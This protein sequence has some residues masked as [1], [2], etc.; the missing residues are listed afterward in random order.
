MTH[1]LLSEFQEIWCV[2]F[3]FSAPP[4]N[5]ARPICLV[6]KEVLTGRT[7]KYWEDDLRRLQS[8][9]YGIDTKALVVAYYAS[10][11][12]GCHLALNWPIPVRL[13]DLCA[14]FRNLTNGQQTLCGKDYLARCPI[15]V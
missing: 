1:P 15:L 12:I 11:E 13:L 5:R 9:P 2:D 6:A 8:P 7:L 10:A 14:E 3:E 4:G